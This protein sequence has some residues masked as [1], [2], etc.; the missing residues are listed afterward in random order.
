M[1]KDQKINGPQE[2]DLFTGVEL[3]FLFRQESA[4]VSGAGT[5]VACLPPREMSYSHASQ[6]CFTKRGMCLS[7][8]PPPWINN[9]INIKLF[10]QDSFEIQVWGAVSCHPFLTVSR[11]AGLQ[12][13]RWGR[14]FTHGHFNFLVRGEHLTFLLFISLILEG[15][16]Q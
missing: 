2:C 15:K 3:L 16:S 1:S 5:E 14:G 7:P 10:L 11:F 12:P 8:P 6:R 9:K 13:S 4:V